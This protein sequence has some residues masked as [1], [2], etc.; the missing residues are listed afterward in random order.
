MISEKTVGIQ[1]RGRHTCSLSK[2]DRAELSEL[3]HGDK[4]LR[5]LALRTTPCSLFIR[6][7]ERLY[8][9]LYM[10]MSNIIPS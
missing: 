2:Y 1:L 3:F 8:V 9:K 7:S 5:H 4:R 6:E 10:R